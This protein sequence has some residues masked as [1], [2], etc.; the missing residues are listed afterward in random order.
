MNQIYKVIWN[1]STQQFTAVS[2]LASGYCRS[3]R[4]RSVFGSSSLMLVGVL[5]GGFAVSTPVYAESA[6]CMN[7]G[8]PSEKASNTAPGT[9]AV[10]CGA[11]ATAS[12]QYAIAIGQGAQAS[13]V[14]GTG[15]NQ[16]SPIAIGTNAVAKNGG[17][18]Q[19]ITARRL[20]ADNVQQFGTAYRV[21]Q[22]KSDGSTY[23][24]QYQIKPSSL[25]IGEKSVAYSGGVAVGYNNTA[26]Q[27]NLISGF[28]FGNNNTATGPMSFAFGI[29]N[30]T[31]ATSAI[32]VGTTNRAKGD[33]SIAIGRQTDATG[34]YSTAI[35]NIAIA[36]GVSSFA[37]GHSATASGAR[38]IA[39]GSSSSTTAMYEK[40]TETKASGEDAIAIGTGA[41]AEAKNA[42]SIGTGNVV[43]GENSGAIGDPSIINGANSYSVGNNNVIGSTS[44]NVFI[45]GNAIQAGGT[46]DTS[47]AVTDTASVSGSVALGNKAKISVESGVA[48]GEESNASTAKGVVGYDPLNATADK[49][50]STWTSTRAAVAIGDV[51]D[52]DDT[53]RITRQ[54]TGLAAGTAE[55]DAVN[56]AQL[57][58]AQ[59]HYYSVKSTVT[60]TGSN[61]NNDGA[62]GTN[63][64]AAGVSAAAAGAGATAVGL[65]SNAAGANAV[66]VGSGAKAEAAQ[67]VAIGNT[68]NAAA[69]TGVTS[70]VAVG[71]NA[72]VFGNSGVAIGRNS[73]ASTDGVALG[74]SA[75]ANQA[76]SIAIGNTAYAGNEAVHIGMTGTR[77]NWSGH[78]GAFRRGSTM[79]GYEAAT[80]GL[81]STVTGNNNKILINQR[82]T[83]GGL[84][85]FG[86]AFAGQGAFSHIYGSQNTVGDITSTDTTNSIAVLVTG[87]G[88]TVQ[89]SNGALVSGYGNTLT[90]SAHN[91]I[92]MPIIE[93]G[94][95][96]VA[97]SM[98]SSGTELGQTALIGAGNSLDKGK[99]TLVIGMHNTVKTSNDSSI[100]GNNLTV[101]SIDRSL[102]SGNDNTVHSATD[103]LAMG[104]KQTL[105]SDGNPISGTIV[106]GN[107]ITLAD[108]TEVKNAIAIG[109]K[110]KVASES[111]AIGQAAE[112]TGEQSISIGF[113]NKVHGNNSGAIGD[114]S[115]INAESSYSVGNNNTLGTATTDPATNEITYS[116]KDIFA[117]GNNITTTTNNSVFLGSNA[118][119]VADGTTSKGIDNSY[120]SA[121]IN[122]ITHNFAGGENVAGVVS[123]GN[124]DG[125]RRI[126]NVAPGLISATSTDAINGSQLYSAINSGWNFSIGKTGAGT[127]SISYTGGTGA[128]FETVKLGDT[129]NFIAGDN[130]DITQKGKNITISAK[131]MKG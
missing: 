111:I 64:M 65:S 117:F 72:R 90:N 42:I 81:Y 123:V 106:L 100:T 2:E 3:S 115:T 76:N 97:R 59:T 108:D 23:S 114:P 54:I 130:I 9:N 25:A 38:A 121:T 36:S 27:D 116:G 52:T 40:G 92:V 45:F 63:A 32:S 34:N 28:A 5:L 8:K 83:T 109:N 125:T 75:N 39:L 110:T 50:G 1:K 49:T 99:D 126:Q 88:N 13:F 47:G 101:N 57:K 26:G 18:S 79:I 44:D 7:E 6:V 48:L 68:A 31:T 124:T 96:E 127:N 37:A 112:A 87:S 21:Y 105:G 102:V 128:T 24:A 60:G 43:K 12:A 11:G 20:D 67:G 56:V 69:T 129:L 107:D 91:K 55:T 15:A 93:G 14:A 77:G 19:G 119:Y 131:V 62:T 22:S 98:A 10:A 41:K 30:E 58:A 80:Q 78:S 70:G 74:T 29:G 46:A 122:N 95:S 82:A 113:G 120:K 103:V 73:A 35:G 118:A 71:T 66:A 85:F 86:G 61:Y 84:P 89:N 94:M 51:S 4:S 16:T 53:K 17:G 104:N 33:T